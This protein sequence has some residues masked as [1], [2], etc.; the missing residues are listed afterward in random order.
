MYL[1]SLR[2]NSLHLISIALVA[3]VL[4]VL[5]H[6]EATACPPG[7]GLKPTPGGFGGWSC[8]TL[9][10]FSH[11]RRGYAYSSGGGRAPNYAAAAGSVGL[12]FQG[13]ANIAA[14]TQK[15]GET[16]VEAVRRARCNRS[17]REA[18]KANERGRH[19]ID[20]EEA[21][22]HYELAISMLR[23]CSDHANI[24][25]VT[26]N[27]EIMRYALTAY[28]AP[29]SK[30]GWIPMETSKDRRLLP[31]QLFAQSSTLC[32]H[33]ENHTP[34]WRTCMLR[35]QAELIML[36]SGTI[37]E[38]CQ[39]Q[40]DPD[41]QRQC[42]HNRYA[43]T[44]SKTALTDSQENCYFDERGRPCFPSATTGSGR[45]KQ[46][47]RSRLRDAIDAM[48]DTID[49]KITDAEAVRDSL[50]VGPERDTLTT[51]IEKAKA[52]RASDL[53]SSKSPSDDAY[54]NY[55]KGRDGVLDRSH[56]VDVGVPKTGTWAR[57]FGGDDLPAK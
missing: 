57:D 7:Q 33:A 41:L 23:R 30:G 40:A 9:G 47:G 43:A 12:I 13:M 26:K 42:A 4:L 22:V 56:S 44:L 35:R 39:T 11:Q 15:G 45:G 34:E 3:M 36:M 52:D 55:M 16:D 14:A 46:K 37:R 19:T 28:A 20:P 2:F 25:K 48:P 54:E 53:A 24:A 8:Q 18:Y 32:K 27:I 29:S 1:L 51:M 49:K 6:G 50:P 10:G 5:S 38:A 31:A 21:I 17:F